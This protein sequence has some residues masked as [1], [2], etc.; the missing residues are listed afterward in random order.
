MYYQDN[1]QDWIENQDEEIEND[2]SDELYEEQRER[3]YDEN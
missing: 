1:E 2:R 3:A